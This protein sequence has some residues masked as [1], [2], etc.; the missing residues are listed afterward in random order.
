MRG[1]GEA[2]DSRVR[3]RA[4]TLRLRVR[5]AAVACW[6]VGVLATLLGFT[7]TAGAATVA[8]DAPWTP[9]AEVEAHHDASGHWWGQPAGATAQQA[10]ERR[11]TVTGPLSAD[12]LHADHG[13]AGPHERGSTVPTAATS[14][15]AAGLVAGAAPRGPPNG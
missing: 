7:T 2:G 1:V 9:A 12:G 10:G 6:T 8:V 4:R 11:A 13:D 3:L 5:P 14:A 15:L